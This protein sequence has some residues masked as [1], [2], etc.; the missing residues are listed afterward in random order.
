MREATRLRFDDFSRHL[1]YWLQRND[2]DGAED[3][4]RRQHDQRRVHLSQSF[5]G[6][7]FLDG[8]LDPIG[9]TILDDVLTAIERELFHADRAD[10]KQQRGHDDIRPADLARTPAQRRA[11]AL[12]ELAR[13]AA[14]MPAGAR[15]PEPLFTVHVGYETFAG[16]LCQLANNTVITPGSL[17]PWLDQAWI[18]R[19]VFDGP[20]RIID[21]GAHR[22]L[23]TGATRRAV[24][25][26]DEECFHDLCDT[27]AAACEID[28]IQPWAAGRPTTIDNGRCACRFHNLA[29]HRR[30]PEPPADTPP[31]PEPP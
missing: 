14:A 22:R 27:P 15:K 2:P 1:A 9:G 18:E 3:S 25:L 24:E 10:A 28:H 6:V 19:V 30:A 11:D 7:W 29:R 17:V 20:S 13:R 4:A 31:S 23:F 21:L 16:P 8:V 26:L 5:Q 12:V